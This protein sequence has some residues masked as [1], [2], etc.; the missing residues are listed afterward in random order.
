MLI[1]CC[2]DHDLVWQTRKRVLD[3]LSIF[4]LLAST[5]QKRG[6]GLRSLLALKELGRHIS[7]S[8]PSFHAARKKIGWGFLRRILRKLFTNFSEEFGD[9]YL[10]KGLRAFVIDGTHV[11]V[12]MQLVDKKYV[13]RDKGSHYPQALVSMFYSVGS[14]LPFDVEINRNLDE[15]KAALLLLRPLKRNDL[16]IY[17]RGYFSI[18]FYKS[19]VVQGLHTI[20]RLQKNSKAEI[21]VCWRGKVDRL[22]TIKDSDT[23]I[24]VRVICYKIEGKT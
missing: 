16:I 23:E 13:L 18:V 19:H 1:R 22:V 10:W 15:R 4:V 9:L 5:F 24:T 3:T 7:V 20:F 6:E 17:D 12:P 8:A 14:R 21:E 11:T 2:R